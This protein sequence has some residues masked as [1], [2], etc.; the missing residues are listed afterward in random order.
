[1]AETRKQASL[2]RI[3]RG[4]AAAAGRA[5]GEKMPPHTVK[6][7]ARRTRTTQAR[8]DRPSWLASKPLT[9]VQAS[10]GKS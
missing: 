4:A 6:S 7:A 2:D 10:A 5:G 8:Q 3:D 1:M 9:C